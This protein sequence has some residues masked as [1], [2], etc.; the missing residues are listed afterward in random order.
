[1][2]AGRA[3][4]AGMCTLTTFVP[5]ASGTARSDAGTAPKLMS[6]TSSDSTGEESVRL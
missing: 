2:P 3:G 5:G 6:V 1:M 4:W